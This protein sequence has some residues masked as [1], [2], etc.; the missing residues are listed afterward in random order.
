[1][2]EHYRYKISGP[3]DFLEY[4]NATRKPIFFCQGRVVP[5]FDLQISIVKY[6]YF[7]TPGAYFEINQYIA[8]NWY[9]FDHEECDRFYYG[10][11]SDKKMYEET[12]YCCGWILRIKKEYGGWA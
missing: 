1:M 10:F 12:Y 5:S 11:H 2:S 3:V 4:H 7:T 6:F 8:D 9:M